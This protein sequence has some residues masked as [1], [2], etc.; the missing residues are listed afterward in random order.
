MAFRLLLVASA[1]LA[2]SFASAL[3]CT[4]DAR[5]EVDDGLIGAGSPSILISEFYANAVS[6][7]EYVKLKSVM[8]S[9]TSLCGWSLNDGEGVIKFVG[10]AAICASQEVSVSFNSSS[11]IAAFGS[12][13]DFAIDTT[14]QDGFGLEITGSFRLGD[15]GD[16]ISLVDPSG[17]EVDYVVY[18]DV[19]PCSQAWV[20]APIATPRKGEIV[21][22]LCAE[23]VASDTDAAEDWQ[24][25]REFRYGYT[26]YAP[27]A[28]DVAPGHLCAFLSPDCSLDVVLDK[29][30]TA[31]REIML[32]SYEMQSTELCSELANAIERGVEVRVL[33]DGSPIGGMSSAEVAVLSCLASTGA[34]VRI[35]TGSLREGVVRHFSALHAKYMVIDSEEA[36]ILS[37]NFVKDGIPADRVFGN[38]GWGVAVKS[39]ELASFLAEV[40]DCDARASR[41]DVAMWL[42]DDRYDRSAGMPV[43]FPSK[44]PIGCASPLVSTS[45]STVTLHISPDSSTVA[46][47]AC[48]LMASASDI[49]IEQLQVDLLWATRWGDHATM[50]PLLSA[51]VQRMQEGASCRMLLDSSW[52]NVIGNEEATSAMIVAAYTGDLAGSFRL[53][54]ADSPIALLHN[55]GAVID[56]DVTLVSSNNWVYASFARNRE[57]A[58]IIES[59]EVGAYFSAAFDMDWIPD[60]IPPVVEL[61]GEMLASPGD[62]ITLSPNV[63]WDDRIIVEY[64]W[65]VGHD[66]TVDC[67]E[68]QLSY[69]ANVPGTIEISLTVVDAWGNM[70]TSATSV[71]VVGGDY[72]E[73]EHIASWLEVI[74]PAT[75]LAAGVALV[76]LRK[77]MSRRRRGG[78][79]S[80]QR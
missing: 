66:G 54:S 17:T 67:R 45:S 29:V 27:R 18:G 14:C 73:A 46:P 10:S 58:A 12:A 32:C 3:V 26:E 80:A 47:F 63:A 19:E 24:P 50:N 2:A 22:R 62:R 21:R 38:R 60:T 35:V 5:A 77:A 48:A 75:P 39:S 42:D 68:P 40:F 70:A 43:I 31:G 71:R 69:L 57:L 15:A 37:E 72:L 4:D 23:D 64:L 56:H 9:D 76:L 33:V 1:L 79:V 49:I 78:K 61:E 25:F 6:D 55:K 53:M 74:A 52:Y 65:D 11:Y 8:T 28:F 30:S 7:D 36:V 34:D 13:P 44:H 16:S 20:G 59:H 41:P 51:L